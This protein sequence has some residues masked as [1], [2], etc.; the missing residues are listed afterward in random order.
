MTVPDIAKQYEGIYVITRC[1]QHYDAQRQ[2]DWYRIYGAGGSWHVFLEDHLFSPG[3]GHRPYVGQM[4]VRVRLIPA[5]DQ[6][7]P[8]KRIAFIETF[9]LLEPAHPGI[10]HDE[11]YP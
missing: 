11:L 9:S 5:S 2:G 6:E 7:K 4:L 10:S 1:M 8:I 3:D